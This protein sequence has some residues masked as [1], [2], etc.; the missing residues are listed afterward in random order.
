MLSVFGTEFNL[1]LLVNAYVL[2]LPEFCD[3]QYSI[4]FSKVVIKCSPK[5]FPKYIGN[6]VLTLV[7]EIN[8]P[9][10]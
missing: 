4:L 8:H 2:N 9:D 6:F 3:M 1:D 7:V 10:I 5:V